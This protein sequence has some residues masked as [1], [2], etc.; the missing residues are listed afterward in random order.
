MGSRL[1]RRAK[2]VAPPVVGLA[3]L[4]GLWVWL[5]AVLPGDGK[6]LPT[7]GAVLAALVEDRD[8]IAIGLS[9]TLVSAAEG[10]GAGVAVGVVFALVAVVVPVLR[11]PLTRQLTIVFCLP[12]AA[13]APLLF[14]FLDL[15]GPH[16]VLAAISVV[17]PVYVALVQGLTATHEE[18]EDLRDVL[19][20]SR[21]R[22]FL[23]V[24]LPSA[25]PQFVVAA[26][27]AGP[28]AVLGTTLAEYFGGE[29]GV[30]VLMIN[31][32]ARVDT[33]RAYAL[34]VVVTG[35]SALLYGA[36]GVV[37]S[38]LPWTAQPRASRRRIGTATGPA[39]GAAAGEPA[40]PV[41]SVEAM[42]V[43]GGRR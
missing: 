28:A 18:W 35:L 9:A 19:G 8:I 42:S 26:R 16:V 32:L 13:V 37:A 29:R 6:L 14:L 17:F 23:R 24:Q 36:V 43:D 4:L 15:P 7:P 1:A 11:R 39:A 3:A 33:P 38:L 5:A 41:R 22:Y 21:V 34:G 25:G 12:L 2:V 40:L 20:G 10:L 31:S 27:I 30:G